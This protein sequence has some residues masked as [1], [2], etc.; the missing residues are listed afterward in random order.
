MAI[1]L[2]LTDNTA[3]DQSVYTPFPAAIDAAGTPTRNSEIR[4]SC[5]LDQIFPIDALP[6]EELE[7]RVQWSARLAVLH[8]ED[9]RYEKANAEVQAALGY[10]H[11]HPDRDIIAHLSLKLGEATI[12]IPNAPCRDLLHDIA[13]YYKEKLKADGTPDVAKLLAR[14]LFSQAMHEFYSS[15]PQTGYEL[16]AQC[17]YLAGKYGI[18]LHGEANKRYGVVLPSE[19]LGD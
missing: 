7:S 3:F 10:I 11:R 6:I 19:Q 16:M 15:N 14:V 17:Q 18:D 8:L 5:S 4:E 2:P 9:R 13:V 1:R 12:G